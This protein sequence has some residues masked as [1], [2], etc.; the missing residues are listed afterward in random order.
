MEMI[1]DGIAKVWRIISEI[2]QN[3]R[4]IDHGMVAECDLFI[5]RCRGSMGSTSVGRYSPWEASRMVDLSRRM[6]AGLVAARTLGICV[7]LRG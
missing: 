1:I 2:V 3:D 7:G 6:A 5:N 4:I